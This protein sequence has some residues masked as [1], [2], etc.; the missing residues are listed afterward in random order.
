MPTH[1]SDILSNENAPVLELARRHGLHLSNTMDINELGLDFRVVTAAD[2]SGMHWVLRIPRRPDMLEK[3]EREARILSLLRPRLPFAVPEWR[4]VSAELVAYPKLND[5]TAISVDAATGEITWHIDKDSDDFVAAL[6]RS[7]AALHG[8][9]VHEAIA[10]GLRTST[11]KEIRER[12]ARDIDLVKESFDIAPRLE[13]RWHAWLDDDASWPDHSVV[14]H[15]DLYAGHILV[16]EQN[17]ITGMIDWSEA[18]ISDPSIDF[19]SHLLLFG[20]ASLA[21]LIRHYETAGGRVWPRM[22]HHIAERLTMSP[23]KY[24]LFA[25]ESGEAAHL[26]AAKAQ[27]IQS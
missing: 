18:E 27:L 8:I 21:R 14:V 15:G 6:G 9:S 4:I 16:N 5:P 12:T 20:E 2:D 24:A 23:V 11:S 10:A 1:P 3:I 7:L 26:D 13:R 22:A 19:T 25:L 17:G